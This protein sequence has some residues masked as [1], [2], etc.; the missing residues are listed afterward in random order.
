MGLKQRLASVYFPKAL[1]VQAW[2]A[3]PGSCVVVLMYHE[4]LPDSMHLPYWSIVAESN[5][6]RQ[7]AHLQRYYE[8]L[9]MDAALRYL[10]SGSRECPSSRPLAVITF[11]DG[12]AGNYLCAMPILRE[13]GLPFLVY[14]ATANVA[15]GNRPWYDDVSVG[16]LSL[17][18]G[19][20]RIPTS[21]GLLSYSGRHLLPDRRWAAVNNILGAI[22]DLPPDE[23]EAIAATFGNLHSS[24]PLRM[25]SPA[26]ITS[27]ATEPLASIGCHTHGHELL[28]KVPRDQAKASIMQAQ[29]LLEAWTG[30]CPAHFSYP[31]GNYSAG[32]CKLLRESGFASAVTTRNRAWTPQDDRLEIPRIAVGRFDN[33]NLFRAKVAGLFAERTA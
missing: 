4:V 26:E 31:N 15:A 33:M 22:K 1:E 25:M 17:G 9:S 18:R 23:Q 13:L 24:T 11:D 21:R 12:Y 19:T 2:R 6:R 7:M 20:T 14:V 27:L 28:D 3:A 16:L 29:A 8:V 32:T 5:F 30:Q 10:Y